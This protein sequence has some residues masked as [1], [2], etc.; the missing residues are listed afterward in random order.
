MLQS[1]T[2]QINLCYRRRVERKLDKLNT[3]L[4]VQPSTELSKNYDQIVQRSRRIEREDKHVG[5]PEDDINVI[6]F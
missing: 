1:Y 3:F 5:P 6:M 4:S 2:T